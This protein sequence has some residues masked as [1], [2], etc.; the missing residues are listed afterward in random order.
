MPFLVLRWSGSV[1]KL[2]Q[3]IYIKPSYQ[4]QFGPYSII[5]SITSDIANLNTLMQQLLSSS[6]APSTRN[7]YSAAFKRYNKFC[8]EH[9]LSTQL[10]SYENNLML[11]VTHLSQTTSYS[12]IK[13]NLA[14]IKHFMMITGEF[15]ESVPSLPRLYLLI[16]GIK[17]THRNKHKKPK[18]LPICSKQTLHVWFGQADAVGCLHHRILWVFEI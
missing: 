11:Y 14:A 4:N 9:N 5:E 15:Q 1:E 3:Q 13:I 10:A 17:R 16:R 12:Y 18:R 2:Q 8:S 7:Q 6:I